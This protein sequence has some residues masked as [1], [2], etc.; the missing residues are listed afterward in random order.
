MKLN[1]D[2]NSPFT[3]NRSVIKEYIEEAAD[4]L[5]LDMD[6]GYTTMQNFFNRNVWKASG[7]STEEI[8]SYVDSLLAEMDPQL[9]FH[10]KWV[11]EQLWFLI[12]TYYEDLK[13]NSVALSPTVKDD[14]IWWEVVQARKVSEGANFA[15][16]LTSMHKEFNEAY[17]KSNTLI[18]KLVLESEASNQTE[19]E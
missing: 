9:R 10:A 12:Q 16:S 5:L 6:T 2:L 3:G 7:K 11:D 14:E 19:E 18:N 8:E 1:Y 15:G 13:G 17:D 4:F